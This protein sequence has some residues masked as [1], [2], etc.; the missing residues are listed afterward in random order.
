MRPGS[1]RRVEGTGGRAGG[2]GARIAVCCRP[3]PAESTGGGGA[4]L[5]PAV[6]AP[7][8]FVGGVL[9]G[10]GSPA[11]P[12]LQMQLHGWRFAPPQLLPLGY[13]LMRAG[14]A[15]SAA[16]VVGGARSRA[17]GVAGIIGG[18]LSRRS[19]GDHRSSRRRRMHQPRHRDLLLLLISDLLLD[20]DGRRTRSKRLSPATATQSTAR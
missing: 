11:P 18:A 9:C 4:L 2:P 10:G 13:R 14:G 16:V 15:G 5:P 7:C 1:R 6:V 20:A 3:P 12:P 19:R 17:H 8:H